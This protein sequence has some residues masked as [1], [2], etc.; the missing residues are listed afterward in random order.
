MVLLLREQHRFEDK[1]VLAKLQLKKSLLIALFKMRSYEDH[2]LFW[3]G[4]S[5]I[6]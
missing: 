2:P 5:Y 3:Y 6:H 4:A 1:I